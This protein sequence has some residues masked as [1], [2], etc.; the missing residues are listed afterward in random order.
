MFLSALEASDYQIGIFM[1]F[2]LLGDVVL[3]G[4]FTLTA[5]QSGRR[6]VL[7]QGYLFM[8]FTGLAFALVDNFW[9]LLAIAAVGV[10]SATGG[11]FG[12]FR[13]IEE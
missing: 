4:C 5:D 8:V 1:T 11:D 9:I 10:V 6:Q 7:V 12:P 2:T 3:S 13:A